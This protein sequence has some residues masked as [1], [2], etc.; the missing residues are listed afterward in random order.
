MEVA[1]KDIISG[2]AIPERYISIPY[3]IHETRPII[4]ATKA[5][6]DLFSTTHLTEAKYSATKNNTET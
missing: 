5:R 3:N 6:I 1:I 4:K 2:T